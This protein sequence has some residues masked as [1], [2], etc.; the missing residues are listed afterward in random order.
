[1]CPVCVANMTL[2]AVGAS[3]TS[4]VAAFAVK[5]FFSKPVRNQKKNETGKEQN[6]NRC[7]GIRNRSE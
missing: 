4:G 2:I 6:E 3:S 7:N 5:R 1:M